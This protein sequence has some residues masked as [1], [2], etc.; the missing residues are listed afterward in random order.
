VI[1][2]H[3]GSLSLYSATAFTVSF[4]QAA[5]LR[6]SSSRPIIGERFGVLLHSNSLAIQKPDGVPQR[7]FADSGQSAHGS[8]HDLFG[9][10]GFEMIRT[11]V[12][13][14]PFMKKRIGGLLSGRAQLEALAESVR[15]EDSNGDR[16]RHQ[17][18]RGRARHP[19]RGS[20]RNQD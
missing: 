5:V 10:S 18:S 8:I 17:Q 11:V 19:A 7:S 2:G 3:A 12:L 6:R 9:C 15:R 20:T 13:T 14:F 16:P 1:R 4:Y